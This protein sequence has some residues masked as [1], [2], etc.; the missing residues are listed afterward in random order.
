M[1][2]MLS[3]DGVVYQKDLGPMRADLAASINSYNPDEGW[4]PA[5]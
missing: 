3:R 5:E 2:F 1:T 4:T